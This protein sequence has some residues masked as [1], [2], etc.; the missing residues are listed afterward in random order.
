MA[1]TTDIL[2]TIQKLTSIC[3]PEED[4]VFLRPL[5]RPTKAPPAFF[6]RRFVEILDILA[7]F[8]SKGIACLIKKRVGMVIAT[9]EVSFRWSGRY[10]KETTETG[11]QHHV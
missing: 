3:L 4:D 10:Q 5:R 2:S 8:P 6:S 9:P 7:I 11:V 1:K